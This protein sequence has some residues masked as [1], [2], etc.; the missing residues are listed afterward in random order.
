LTRYRE[1]IEAE[2]VRVLFM[3]E[4]H[5]IGGDVDG[6]VWGLKGK[7]V[8]VPVVNE[9]DRQTYYGAL[10]LLSKRLLLEAHEAGN[11][12]CTIAYLKFL[13]QQFPAQR[14]LILWDGASYHR[15]KELRAFLEQLNE[16]LP[17]DQWKIHCVR[18]APNAPTQNPIEDVWLRAKTWLRRM[19]GLRPCFSA[20]KAL[21]EQ[22]CSLNTFDFPK[23]H[24]YGQFS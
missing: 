18:F 4:C 11:T 9:R 13:Q 16:G 19:S 7:R 1:A 6:Y 12:T 5:L 24:M 22:F 3:D 20:L 2:Q 14:L 15:S 21:F 17:E 23:L 8:E 10:N